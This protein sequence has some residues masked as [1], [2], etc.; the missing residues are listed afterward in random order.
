MATKKASK[1]KEEEP[2][3][4]LAPYR[5]DSNIITR[6]MNILLYGPQGAGKTYMAA[7]AQD[8]PDM[9]NV[10]FLNCEGG[11][12]SIAHRGDI[13]A[14]DITTID[15]LEEVCLTL[16]E[17]GY[18]G[19]TTVVVDSVTELQSISLTGIVEESMASNPKDKHTNRDELFLA[20]Y[21]HSTKQLSR[22]LRMF[23]DLPLNVVL[24]AHPKEVYPPGSKG[25][26]ETATPLSIRPML[27]DKLCGAVMGYWDFVWYLSDVDGENPRHLITHTDGTV[28]VKTR[29]AP[30]SE[31]LLDEYGGIVEDPDLPTL[32]NM[33]CTT[34][35]VTGEDK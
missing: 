11:L 21:G 2:V 33:F 3:D 18:E 9:A 26:K 5:V 32:Y 23:R 17:G 28:K 8:H 7:T 12:I 19:V 29:G 24:I 6:G 4:P 22:I 30:F 35:G 1:K 15:Q 14:V 20:D 10:L 25:P 34:Q 13:D 27:T 31:H 16:K